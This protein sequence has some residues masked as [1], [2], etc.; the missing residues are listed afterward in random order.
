MPSTLE[1]QIQYCSMTLYSMPTPSTAVERAVLHGLGNV[2]FADDVLLREV[3]DGARHLEDARIGA[4]GEV[5]FSLD[6]SSRARA[7]V[8][9][10][11]G[12]VERARVEIGVDAYLRR[13]VF[14]PLPLPGA[15]SLH[16]RADGGGRLRRPDG[17]E[18]R[19]AGMDSTSMC[20]SMRSSM[21]P[22]MRFR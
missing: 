8:V 3:G 1:S 2:F 11:A 6:S 4:V 14:V 16:A 20:M 19:S 22:E 17:P 7:F 10:R 12:A 5:Q 15:G 18:S 9:I 13:I 21:R